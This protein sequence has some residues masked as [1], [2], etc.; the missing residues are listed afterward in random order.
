MQAID[1][2]SITELLKNYK[3]DQGRGVLSVGIYCLLQG[4]FCYC[5]D[6]GGFAQV[7]GGAAS[8]H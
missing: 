2:P 7:V 1:I 3:K 4:A 5:Q 8:G 6:D